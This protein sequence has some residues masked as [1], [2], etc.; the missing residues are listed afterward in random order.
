MLSTTPWTHRCCSSG[1]ADHL[2][3]S[4]GESHK[5]AID[6]VCGPEGE[7]CVCYHNGHELLDGEETTTCD[8]DFFVCWL[9]DEPPQA[10]SVAAEGNSAASP[11]SEWVVTV[12]YNCSPAVDNE[13]DNRQ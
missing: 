6:T 5:L 13:G 3:Q 7:L 4:R 8:R 2:L 12:E 9:D 1:W 11:I 10:G